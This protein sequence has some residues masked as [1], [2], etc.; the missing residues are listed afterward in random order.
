MASFQI[1]AGAEKNA[2]L[3]QGPQ[4]S[5]LPKMQQGAFAAYHM[6]KLR[7]LQGRASERRPCKAY[8]ERP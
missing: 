6:P 8:K 1:K 7:V 2:Y 3:P 5:N 4:T